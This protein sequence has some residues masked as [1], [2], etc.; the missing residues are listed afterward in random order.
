M[1]VSKR[2]FNLETESSFAIF[3]KSKKLESE[4]KD[5]INLGIGQPDFATPQNILQI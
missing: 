2:L 1:D 3:A 5:I 4:G